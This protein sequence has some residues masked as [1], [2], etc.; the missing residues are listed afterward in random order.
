MQTAA[1][2]EDLFKLLEER[3]KKNSQAHYFYIAEPVK[4]KAYT[5][6]GGTMSVMLPELVSAQ[7]V[8]ESYYEKHETLVLLERL[9][10]GMVFFDVG[11]HV[12]YF[13]L[14]A[15]HLVGET[16]QVHSFEPTPRTFR[17]LAD[18]AKHHPNITVNNLAVYSHSDEL[19]LN[20][21]G[22]LNFAF[23]SFFPAR[24]ADGRAVPEVKHRIQTVSLDEYV[25]RTGVKPDVIKVDAESAE[26]QIIDGMKNTLKACRPFFMIEV[27]DLDLDGVRPCSEIVEFACSHGYKPLMYQDGELKPH[28]VAD[29]Y[30]G[31]GTVFFEPLD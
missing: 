11:A 17:L 19:I 30:Q 2:N 22:A 25:E 24:V 12:G 13:T 1:L 23:N 29:R 20:D 15:S 10:P 28:K 27:G 8:S 5:F 16:G 9:R 14:L 18:N 26:Y 7:I 6:W 3:E 4:V 31:W 21:F